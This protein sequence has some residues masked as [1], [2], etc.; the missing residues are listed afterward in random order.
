LLFGLRRPELRYTD[1][2]HTELAALL[3]VVLVLLA[4]GLAPATLFASQQT[5]PQTSTV[6][7]VMTWNR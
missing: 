7:D 1:V 4:L 5:L 2:L 3:I 6:M